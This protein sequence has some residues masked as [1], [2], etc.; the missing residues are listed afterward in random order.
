MCCACVSQEELDT[1]RDAL[2]QGLSLLQ[3]QQTTM[4]KQFQRE[5]KLVK[6][7]LLDLQGGGGGGSAPGAG[8]G[9]MPGYG[10]PPTGPPPMMP[11]QGFYQR[12]PSDHGHEYVWSQIY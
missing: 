12:P 10:F 9:Y 11:A 8:P 2:S 3:E 1:L 7:L 5:M 4:M 6:S